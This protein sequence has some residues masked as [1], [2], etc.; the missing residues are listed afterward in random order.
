MQ[1][2]A[3]QLT[4]VL[5]VCPDLK[6]P[7]QDHLNTFTEAQRLHVPSEVQEIILGKFNVAPLTAKPPPS[8][9]AGPEPNQVSKNIFWRSNNNM[10][11]NFLTCIFF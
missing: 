11:N 7:L 5:T 3:P 6:I 1:L 2:P 8:L 4:E 10:F 9:N